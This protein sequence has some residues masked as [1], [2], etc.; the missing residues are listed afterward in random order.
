MVKIGK[1]FGR[2][3]V[4]TLTDMEQPLGCA[5]G[6]A[7]EV[8]EAI[9]TLKGNGPKDFDT[10]CRALSAE[11]LLVSNTA[12]NEEVAFEMVDEVIKNGKALE[13]LTEMIVH[14]H[15]DPRVIDDYSLMGVAENEIELV[16]SSK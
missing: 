2:N 1:N 8:V 5:V 12:S 15:G 3:T 13:K 14:Q 6:N 7:L 9:E 16:S 11:I 10:L 4:A